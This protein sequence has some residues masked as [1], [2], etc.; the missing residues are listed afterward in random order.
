MKRN[1]SKHLE[2]WFATIQMSFV[3]L[4]GLIA[5][6]VT[7]LGLYISPEFRLLPGWFVGSIISTTVFL[8]AIS[9]EVIVDIIYKYIKLDG[10]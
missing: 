6:S 10:K 9:L 2:D 5:S 7:L 4:G 8:L 1:K 3:L